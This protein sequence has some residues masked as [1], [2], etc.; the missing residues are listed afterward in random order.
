VSQN[1]V[2]RAARGVGIELDRIR[3][4]RRARWLAPAVALGIGIL[5]AFIDPLGIVVGSGLV[6]LPAKSISRG[7]LRGL[8]FGV[9]VVGLLVV[10]LLVAGTLGPAVAL[11]L[12]FSLAVG[13]GVVFGLLGGLVR[14]IV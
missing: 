1:R 9:L 12:P 11:G 3:S 13:I 5:A 2:R 6:A 14:G 8:G 4:E 7:I 10:Q